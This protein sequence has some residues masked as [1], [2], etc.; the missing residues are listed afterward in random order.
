MQEERRARLNHIQCPGCRRDIN[1]SR[2]PDVAFQVIDE[3]AK[4]DSAP[5]IAI[6]VGRVEVHR[7]I[8]CPDGQYR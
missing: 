2:P 4:T 6:L 3:R 5:A 8:E 7:C 1:V